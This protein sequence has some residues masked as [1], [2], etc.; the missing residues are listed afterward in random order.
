[1]GQ[2]PVARVHR[3]PALPGPA[4]L[5]AVLVIILIGSAS[6]AMSPPVLYL[7]RTSPP[8]MYLLNGGVRRGLRKGVTPTER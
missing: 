8:I 5:S 4:W 3:T 2:Q 6:A 7:V 1:V